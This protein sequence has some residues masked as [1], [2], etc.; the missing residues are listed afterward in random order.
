MYFIQCQTQKENQQGHSNL[1]NFKFFSKMSIFY[2]VHGSQKMAITLEIA[3]YRGWSDFQMKIHKILD[4]KHVKHDAWNY[5][6]LLL[7][8][9]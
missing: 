9:K 1:A 4:Y 6:E 3:V 2:L 7:F 8:F 5:L